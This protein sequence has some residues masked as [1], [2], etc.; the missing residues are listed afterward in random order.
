V[1]FAL[2]IDGLKIGLLRFQHVVDH[3]FCDFVRQ[4]TLYHH[5][6]PLPNADLGL[7]GD[8]VLS[9]LKRVVG[10]QKLLKLSADVSFTCAVVRDRLHEC[11][12][13]RFDF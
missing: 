13:D 9:T 5:F 8:G 12:M 2:K 10:F 6:V 4:K 11:G 3:V 1:G 7:I